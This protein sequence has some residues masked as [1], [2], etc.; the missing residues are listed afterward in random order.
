MPLLLSALLDRRWAPA[1]DESRRLRFLTTQPFAHRGLHGGRV[2]ENSRAA[3]RAA[4][5]LGHGIEC[6]VQVSKDGV[7][8]VFHDYELDR[9]TDESGLV[10]DRTAE[11]L[12]RIK[13]KG[14]DETIPTLDDMLALVAGKVPLLIEV[15]LDS[16][17]INPLCLSVRRS[18]EGYRG[19]AAVMSFNPYVGRWFEKN[20]ELI[21]RGL[22][23]TEEG[24]AG[25]RGRY[26]R[27]WSLW[28]S[29]PDFLAYD[30][31]DLPSSFAESQRQRGIPVLT[32]TVRTP[33]Q[34]KTAFNAADEIIY[35]RVQHG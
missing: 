27:H 12:Q 33:D 29:S 6:D 3:F 18:L 4:I 21:I 34:E 17:R 24:K 5:A 11:E 35:E 30:I 10:A 20:G 25:L 26:E 15:K 14:T 31:R 1:P 23:V 7:A 13:L 16:K 32:W 22:V 2:L 8:V 28:K 19:P 9:L